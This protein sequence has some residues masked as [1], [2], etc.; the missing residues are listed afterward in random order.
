MSHIASELSNELDHVDRSDADGLVRDWWCHR[1]R[2]LIAENDTLRSDYAELRVEYG[3]MESENVNATLQAERDALV[4]QADIRSLREQYDSIVAI[5]DRVTAERNELRDEV[6]RMLERAILQDKRLDALNVEVE[7]LKTELRYHRNVPVNH[8]FTGPWAGCGCV[9]C[10]L[11]NKYAAVEAERDALA[12]RWE[13]LTDW[14]TH[15]DAL[16]NEDAGPIMA[17]MRELEAT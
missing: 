1:I 4:K 11:H 6:N 9:A 17:K 10:N 13:D 16:T 8:E 3:R 5:M 2:A 12:K 7:Q 15:S 14:V